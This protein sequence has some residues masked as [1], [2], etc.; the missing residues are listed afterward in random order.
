MSKQFNIIYNYYYFKQYLI[1]LRRIRMFG[2]YFTRIG[3]TTAVNLCFR[4]I[5]SN[6]SILYPINEYYYSNLKCISDFIGTVHIQRKL[7]HVCS[8]DRS[9]VSGETL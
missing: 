4:Q 7:L 5:N 6:H 3:F 8:R 1:N 9:E 2:F